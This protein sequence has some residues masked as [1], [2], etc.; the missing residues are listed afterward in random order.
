MT[1]QR[2]GAREDY[3]IPGTSVLRNKFTTPTQP[4]GVTDPQLL[5]HLEAHVVSTRLLELE[6]QP[7]PGN[8]DYAHMKAIHRY[9]FQDVYEWAGEPRCG[10]ATAM[11]KQGPNVLDH[12]RFRVAAAHSAR[13]DQCA[14]KLGHDGGELGTHRGDCRIP[15]TCF[16]RC[17]EQV[18]TR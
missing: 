3:F 16:S 8:F 14:G 6:Q 11:V 10:P 13:I 15:L 1:T 12:S 9:L 2:F 7:L 4:F 5:E 18:S 17:G